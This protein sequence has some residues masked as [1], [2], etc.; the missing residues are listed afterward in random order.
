MSQNGAS[1]AASQGISYKEILSFYYPRTTLTQLEE[2]HEEEYNRKVLEE[3]KVRVEIAMQ[4][5]KE[6]L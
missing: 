2:S 6:G 1:N 3:I 4:K 5:I